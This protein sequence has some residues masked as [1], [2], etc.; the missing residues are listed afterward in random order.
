LLHAITVIARAGL[1]LCSRR[2]ERV[3]WPT[4]RVTPAGAEVEVRRV[5]DTGASTMARR[6]AVEVGQLVARGA[7]A[8]DVIATRMTALSAIPGGGGD[9]GLRFTVEIE[10]AP[11][12]H[13]HRGTTVAVTSWAGTTPIEATIMSVDCPDDGGDRFDWDAATGTVRRN[14]SAV[15]TDGAS[16]VG[17]GQRTKVV[18][19][20]PDIAEDL[21]ALPDFTTGSDGEPAMRA[22]AVI[23]ASYALCL[24][25]A[26]EVD[27][28]VMDR[29]TRDGTEPQLAADAGAMA[30]VGA[31]GGTATVVGPV[32][33]AGRQHV[34]P[35]LAHRLL[36]ARRTRTYRAAGLPDDD[37]EPLR[38]ARLQAGRRV[39][40]AGRLARAHGCLLGQAAGDALGQLVEFSGPATI[41]RDHPDGGPR[42]LVDGGTW[43]TIA[44][45]PTDDTEMALCLARAIVHA[46]GFDRE[47]TAR[48]Y[49][50]WGTGD[51]PWA[52][53][54]E[55]SRSG[56]SL[57]FDMGG[58]TKRAV[59]APTAR[60]VEGGTV[61]E[62]CT[63]AAAG[64]IPSNG[65]LMRVS[66]LGV[67]GAGRPIDL[68]ARAARADAAL[69]HGHPYT[70]GASAAFAV[71]IGH[72]VWT[73]AG[74]HETWKVALDV[75]QG[76]FGDP[77]VAATIEAAADGPPAD[78]IHHMGACATALRNAFFRLLHESDPATALVATVREGGDTDTTAA[79]AG[80]LLGAVHGRGSLPVQWR[81]MVET[82]RPL[83]GR[84][85][86]VH[87]PRP[88]C[89]WPVDVLALAERLLLAGR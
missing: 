48:A 88:R 54:G 33:V 24:V 21:A 46:G 28:A 86:P 67:W 53:E 57:P 32:I 74:A 60:D 26:G 17:T 69:T 44:G 64:S 62:A 13:S 77:A 59:L 61:A 82:C 4:V 31:V 42:W 84:D 10:G 3:R 66:P 8:A 79:I 23:S 71:A 15:P 1:A 6:V 87:H 7:P 43:R 49:M 68:V 12:A 16:N 11:L 40:D 34:D 18:A 89:L 5:V 14:G 9:D 56:G 41:A 22:M 76:P 63:R 73:G 58:T 27:L 2:M 25:A 70:Q 35:T 52:L 36:E 50:R 30:I 19:V 83:A 65:A 37:A 78:F 47:A 38:P 39:G 80:A 55:R 45:Q 85:V 20:P 81:R 51:L 75:A 72:A 29:V